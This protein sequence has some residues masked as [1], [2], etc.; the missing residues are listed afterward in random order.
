MALVIRDEQLAALAARAESDFVAR[1]SR[2]LRD[3]WPWECEAMGEESV[4]AAILKGIDK[5]AR[6]GVTTEREVLRV[7]NVMY[8][9]GHDFD[10]DPAFV[11]VRDIIDR[12]GTPAAQRLDLICALLSNE[13]AS[14]P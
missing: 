4:R 11:W 5:A 8:L 3:N 7:I 2:C 13:R 12:Q 6:Y 14:Q 10:A 1:V 9:L